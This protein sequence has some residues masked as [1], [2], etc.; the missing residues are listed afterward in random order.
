M[1]RIVI[2]VKKIMCGRF[3][4]IAT[5]EQIFETFRLHRSPRFETSYNI[6]PGQKI[7]TVVALETGDYKVVNL[8]WG[9]IPHWSKERSIS[10]RLI[11]A[12]AETLREKS[13]FRTAYRQRRCLIL[14]TGFYEWKKIDQ[15]KQA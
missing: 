8:L 5:P 12:R 4:L 2:S 3:N 13:S 10:N 15:G 6:P 1:G 7:L 9:L 14:A 11:N